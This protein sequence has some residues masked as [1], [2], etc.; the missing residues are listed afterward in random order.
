[1]GLR[2]G[3]QA[4]S[5]STHACASVLLLLLLLL[6]LFVLQFITGARRSAGPNR[7]RLIR[8]ACSVLDGKGGLDS[9]DRLP[10]W[11]DDDADDEDENDD[12]RRK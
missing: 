10:A 4:M 11:C 12:R 7:V 1:V 9:E 3:S 5:C 8:H 6:L 2:L